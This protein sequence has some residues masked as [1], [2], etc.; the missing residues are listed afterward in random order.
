[1][2]FSHHNAISF[3]GSA[4]EQLWTDV[5]ADDALGAAPAYW[6]WGHIHEG[7]AYSRAAIHGDTTAMRCVGHSAV[8]NGEAWEL[9][10]KD[11]KTIPQVSYFANTPVDPEGES[12]ARVF[13]G[14]ALL[15]ICKETSRILE[16]EFFELDSNG[17]AIKRWESESP[18]N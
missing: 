10:G 5:T 15:T 6:Y 1:M 16:E 14:F 2:L 9:L 7:I 13:N 8:P 3:A 12:T 11:G 17:A 18:G 4:C